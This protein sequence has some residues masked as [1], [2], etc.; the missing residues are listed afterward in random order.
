MMMVNVQLNSQLII[1]IISLVVIITISGEL[2]P[3]PFRHGQITEAASKAPPEELF[4]G[5]AF[6]LG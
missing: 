6:F 3:G 5:G 4:S 2:M 1:V